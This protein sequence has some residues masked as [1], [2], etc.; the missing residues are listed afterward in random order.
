MLILHGL[1]IRLPKSSCS[2]DNTLQL[3][4][5]MPRWIF[6]ARYR[7]KIRE[8]DNKDKTDLINKIDH[9]ARFSAAYSFG[10]WKAKTQ[11]D[12][13]FFFIQRK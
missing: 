11:A 13:A 7:L 10:A 4:Y 1:S 5:V 3:T 6:S 12:L 2:L 9:R 8:K